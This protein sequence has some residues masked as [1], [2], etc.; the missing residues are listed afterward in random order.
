MNRPRIWAALALAGFLSLGFFSWEVTRPVRWLLRNSVEGQGWHCTVDEARWV[1][2]NRL[3]LSGVKVQSPGGGRVHLAGVQVFPK[4]SSLWK[5]CLVTEW[6][7]EEIRMD[8][9]SWGIRKPAAQEILSSGPVTT[10][11]VAWLQWKPEEFFLERLNLEG[12]VLRVQAEG[13]MRT[14]RQEAHLALK[15]FLSRPVLEGMSLLSPK[16]GLPAWESFEMH[17][18]GGLKAPAFRFDSS[19]LTFAMNQPMERKP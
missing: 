14:Q 8:P 19:F 15:G 16:E 1:P 3:E 9:G 2:W 5:G 4:L 11:G 7:L 18:E 17:L 6:N 13:W 12:P 10:H